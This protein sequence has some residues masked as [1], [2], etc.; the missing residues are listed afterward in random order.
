MS[1]SAL[2][3]GGGL[4][5]VTAIGLG[6]GFVAAKHWRK[7]VPVR[8]AAVT[9]TIFQGPEVTL[10]GRLQAQKTET[11]DAPVAGILDQWFVDV[12]QEVYGN[13]LVGRIRN[14]DLDHAVEQAQAA[15]DRAEV[16]IAQLDAQAVNARLEES[17]TAADQIRARNEFDRIEKIYLRYKN[18]MDAGA[19]ARLT[20]E[21]TEAEYIAAKTEAENRE[22]AAKEA[23]DKAAAVQQESAEAARALAERTAAL[24]KAKDAVAEGDLHS[25]A[26]GV[27]LTRKVHQGD[28]VEESA[29]GLLTIATGLTKLAVSLT[30]DPAVLARIHVRQQA[31]VRVDDKESPGAIKEV[32]GTEVIVEFTNAE[33]ITKLGTAAQVRIVF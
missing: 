2:V 33:P 30:P 13:Q 31:F 17:R 12:G 22:R 15:V 29:E 16:R 3:A 14:A 5:A 1:K 25:P 18:L 24:A 7:P 8:P 9:S 28:Q 10:T 23:Q 21:K 4:L 32:R 11:V 6:L 26:D 19:I 20:F 27:V